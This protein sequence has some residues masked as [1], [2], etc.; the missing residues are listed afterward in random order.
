MRNRIFSSKGHFI[1]AAP[2]ST[3]GLSL[4]S[5]QLGGSPSHKPYLHSFHYPSNPTTNLS[6]E[7]LDQLTLSGSNDSNQVSKTIK[8]SNTNSQATSSANRSDSLLKN[9][10]QVK[11]LNQ[12]IIDTPNKLNLTRTNSGLSDQLASSSSAS[13]LKE[14]KANEN[15][16]DD[17]VDNC[18]EVEIKQNNNAGNESIKS[19]SPR[20]IK[21]KVNQNLD[22]DVHSQ[23]NLRPSS[24]NEPSLAPKIA[25]THS[26]RKVSFIK[27]DHNTESLESWCKNKITILTNLSLDTKSQLFHKRQLS[28]PHKNSKIIISEDEVIGPSEAISDWES[29]LEG[30]ID[31]LAMWQ[32]ID[33]YNL[34]DIQ[35]CWTDVVEEQLSSL[36]P[37]SI[38][39]PSASSSLLPTQFDSTARTGRNDPSSVNRTPIQANRH[40]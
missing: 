4:P 25:D 40:D 15:D 11:D 19:Q 23:S 34:D 20:S 24:D 13:S 6:R 30:L 1:P 27:V 32:V 3:T 38:Y 31:R 12:K 17:Q 8:P 36:F 21:F 26:T 10:N 28:S 39:D 33:E 14:A 29:L 35:R 9:F 37:T 7:F 18:Q 22:E 5:S 2:Q 16:D